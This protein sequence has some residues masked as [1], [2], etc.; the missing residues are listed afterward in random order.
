M[1]II[2]RA[3]H[4]PGFSSL[5]RMFNANTPPA[6]RRVR[7][8]AGGPGGNRRKPNASATAELPYISPGSNNAY[9]SKAANVPK[10]PRVADTRISLAAAMKE[11][12]DEMNARLKAEEEER[13]REAAMRQ[14][15]QSTAPPPSP[16]KSIPPS[17]TR[18]VASGRFLGWLVSLVLQ[19]D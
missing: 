11:K 19:A 9:G 2:E 3:N 5:G 1:F 14:L 17:P 12:E 18:S 15:R 10:P 7:G 13:E 6:P 4:L 8:L 16:T